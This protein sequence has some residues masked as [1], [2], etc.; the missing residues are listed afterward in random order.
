MTA[1]RVPGACPVCARLTID[2][3]QHCPQRKPSA[4]VTSCAA[5]TCRGCGSTYAAAGHTPPLKHFPKETQ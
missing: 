1:T 5:M 4:W 2:N 3:T